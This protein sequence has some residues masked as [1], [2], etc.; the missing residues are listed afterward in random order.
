MKNLK[1]SFKVSLNLRKGI[2]EFYNDYGERFIVKINSLICTVGK[3][4]L[5]KTTDLE[6]VIDYM[7]DQLIMTTNGNTIVYFGLGELISLVLYLLTKLNATCYI[8]NY[9][10]FLGNKIGP[11]LVKSLRLKDGNVNEAI[12]FFYTI[13]PFVL[14]TK[15]ENK[16]HKFFKSIRKYCFF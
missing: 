6:V 12:V 11:I 3:E 16:L 10:E 5:Y 1:Q 14:R 4:V 9:I 13:V 15:Y 7:A 8:N 2:I